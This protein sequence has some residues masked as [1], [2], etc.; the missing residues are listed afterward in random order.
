MAT[1]FRA[2]ANCNPVAR[3]PA[4]N[5]KEQAKRGKGGNRLVRGCKRGVQA[6]HTLY[7]Q[8]HPTLVAKVTCLAKGSRPVYIR[9]RIQ[10]ADLN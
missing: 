6:S 3:W 4:A 2:V 8:R 1:F 10:G 7:T 5:E 9:V